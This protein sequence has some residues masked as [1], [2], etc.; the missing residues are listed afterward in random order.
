MPNSDSQPLLLRQITC[1]A[2]FEPH[3][4]SQCHSFVN[5]P[6]PL[7]EVLNE[8]ENG[9][10]LNAYEIVISLIELQPPLVSQTQSSFQSEPPTLSQTQHW[11]IYHTENNPIVLA[12]TRLE[13]HFE[14]Q[15]KLEVEA[16]EPESCD[17]NQD[18][19]YDSERHDSPTL[20]H[21]NDSLSG[22]MHENEGLG[23]DNDK[24]EG[25]DG[26]LR[27]D[28]NRLGHMSDDSQ[29]SDIKHSNYEQ[30]VDSCAVWNGLN[31]GEPVI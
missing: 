10:Q 26:E 25:I 19:Y 12:Q 16:F 15:T 8:A 4:T 17:I 21:E 2:Q 27:E 1:K 22:D 7:N 24:N 6:R 23:G 29:D 14:P 13:T 18:L 31:S 11:N 5:E 30:N 3:F 20:V 28:H 9:P